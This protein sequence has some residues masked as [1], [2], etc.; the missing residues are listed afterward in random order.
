MKKVT[1]IVLVAILLIAGVAVFFIINNKTSQ[2]TNSNSKQT[3]EQKEETK[4]LT[5]E[6]IINKMKEKNTNIGKIVTYNEETDLNKLLG[7]P[8]QYISK[9]TFEDKRIEQTNADNEFLSQEEQN[10]PT[11]GT[12]EVFN[13][14]EDMTKRKEYIEQIS[15]SASMLSQY[16]YGKN[17]ALLR[18]ENDLTPTQAKEYEDLF[19]SIVK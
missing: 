5:A 9:V 15:S 13:N 8:N 3:E 18:L 11:G 16:I 1:I 10:E 2:P 14:S 7:R 19:N 17:N 12:I 4:V 6:E